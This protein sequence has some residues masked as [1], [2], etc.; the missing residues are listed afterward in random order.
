MDNETI[1][2]IKKIITPQGILMSGNGILINSV[3]KTNEILDKSQKFL[4][5]MEARQKR[6][7]EQNIEIISLLRAIAAKIK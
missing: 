7:E 1:E 3:G 2:M 4:F 5:F 6:M